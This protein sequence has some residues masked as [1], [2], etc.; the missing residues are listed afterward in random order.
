MFTEG[1]TLTQ[2]RLVTTGAV[3]VGTKGD[4][5]SVVLH[6]KTFYDESH[7]KLII[8][9]VSIDCIL[10]RKKGHGAAQLCMQEADT[11]TLNIN[12]PET[13]KKMNFYLRIDHCF[14]E[15]E[16]RGGIDLRSISHLKK[17]ARVLVEERSLIKRVSSPV[18]DD[19]NQDNLYTVEIN[20]LNLNPLNVNEEPVTE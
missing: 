6:R 13:K 12:E 3:Q 15:D 9:S 20:L 14:L 17:M 8:V 19:A 5:Q 18:T 2:R 10:S 16:L 1:L 4:R 7:D 11:F